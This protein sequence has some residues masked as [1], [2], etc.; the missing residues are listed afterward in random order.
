VKV[1][2]SASL[3]VDTVQ[4][5]LAVNEGVQDAKISDQLFPSLYS[6]STSFCKSS[7]YLLNYSLILG[8]L[9]ASS[10]LNVTWMNADTTNL[11]SYQNYLKEILGPPKFINHTFNTV[12][13]NFT[14]NFTWVEITLPQVSLNSSNYSDLFFHPDANSHPSFI[15][16][17][18]AQ[19]NS[20]S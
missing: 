4:N 11:V 15:T 12:I 6:K 10:Y 3:L 19:I 5:Y 7:F 14:V 13:A 9:S 8:P 1:E 17:A 20:T 16:I 2:N 18:N